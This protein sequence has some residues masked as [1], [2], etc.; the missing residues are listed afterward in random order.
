MATQNSLGP[1]HL[2]TWLMAILLIGLAIAASI[3]QHSQFRTDWFALSAYIVLLFAVIVFS[4]RPA[5]GRR[6]F[7]LTAAVLFGL[8]AVAGSLLFVL[9]P[10]WLETLGS[11][12]TLIVV[13]DLLVTMSILWRVTTAKG[14]KSH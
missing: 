9:F 2:P 10:R 5:W 6:A 11:L 1:R 4:F 14:Q 13:F 8:H 7:W 3:I 12:L